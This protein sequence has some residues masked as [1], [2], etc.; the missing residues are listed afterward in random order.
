MNHYAV[1]GHP[2]QHSLSPKIHEAFAQ[3]TGQTLHYSR[4][5]PPINDFIAAVQ[6]FQ[7]EGGRG[8]N[9]TLPFKQ[10]AYKIAQQR[11][12][13]AEE[14]KAASVLH[15][16][17][18]GIYA[19]NFDG[20]GLVQD[21]TKNHHLSLQNRRILLIGAGGAAQGILGPLC[22]QHPAQIILANRTAEKAVQLANLFRSRGNVKGVGLD[23]LKNDYD[24]IIHATSLGH[25]S[26]SF[27][28]PTHLVHAKTFCY[29]ISYGKAAQPFLNWARAQ[30]A[31]HTSD[32]LGMLVEHNALVFQL[33]FGI[34]PQTQP[35]IQL[36]RQEI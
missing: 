27:M 18:T 3:Q 11:S 31:Q 26:Q 32:G 35:V 29:D 8:L 23:A 4:I 17:E 7:R 30:G 1:I 20:L 22:D 34:Q 12:A 6:Q 15:F 36:L 5:E 33:W 25:Q 2:V 19:D 13:T 9:V 10:A 28:L 21:L 16:R 24:L 14:A